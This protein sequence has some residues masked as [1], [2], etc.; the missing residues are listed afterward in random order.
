MP[1]NAYGENDDY[2][3][4]NSHFFPALIKKIIEAIRTNKNYIELWGNGKA[5]R[6]LIFSDDV[7]SA[8]AF[9]LK[10]KNKIKN[11]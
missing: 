1:C 4:N 8:C 7:A 6:E 9:F 3:S 2:D 11:I 10:K 5:L